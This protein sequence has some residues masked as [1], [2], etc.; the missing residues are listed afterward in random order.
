M[1]IVSSS[2]IVSITIITITIIKSLISAKNGL[3]KRKIKRATTASKH[4][5]SQS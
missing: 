3:A 2:F 4:L 5:G 1:M